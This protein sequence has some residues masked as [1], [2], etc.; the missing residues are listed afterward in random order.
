V[1]RGSHADLLTRG[2]HYSD[3]YQTQFQGK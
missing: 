3:L 2:G 1:E